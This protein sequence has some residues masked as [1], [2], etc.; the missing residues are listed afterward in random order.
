MLRQIIREELAQVR[1]SLTKTTK[2][3]KLKNQPKE[4]E[5][6]KLE[7]GLGNNELARRLKNDI[8]GELDSGSLSKKRRKCSE[9]QLAAWTKER[10]PDGIAWRFDGSTNKYFPINNDH[11]R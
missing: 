9:E 4:S 10:D 8:G 11:E 1:R 5:P 3:T 2:R 7:D 6:P